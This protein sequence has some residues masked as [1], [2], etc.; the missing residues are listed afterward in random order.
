MLKKVIYIPVLSCLLCLLFATAKSQQT[1]LWTEADRSYLVDNLTQTRDAL[2]KETQNL[3]DAQWNFKESKDRWSIKEVVE[4]I[5]IWELLLTHEVSRALGA[6]VQ[7]DLARNP[8][9][10]TMFLRFIMEETP[11]ISVEY[12][13]PFT[14]TLPMGLNDGKNN[15]AWFV[16]MRNESIGY[17]KIATEDLRYYYLKKGRPNVHQV[18]IY[19]FGHGERHLRQIRKVKANVNYPNS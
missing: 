11:H 4:H 18:Y 3:T 10:D 8:E 12:T 1:R 14:Y 2:I 13:K 7:A 17:L 15:L 16:K 19:I 6:G 9:P 5:A